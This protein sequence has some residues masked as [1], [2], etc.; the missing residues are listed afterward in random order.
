MFL[1]LT[2]E[3]LEQSERAP[4]LNDTATQAEAALVKP[5]FYGKT[6]VKIYRI[7]FSKHGE[8]HAE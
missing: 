4:A 6:I 1:T 8:S 7:F 5:Y 3:W 2:H